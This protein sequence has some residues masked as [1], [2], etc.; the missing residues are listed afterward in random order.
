MQNRKSLATGLGAVLAWVVVALPVTAVSA[1]TWNVPGNGSNVCTVGNPNCNTIQSAVTASTSGDTILI[2]AGT[3]S[4]TGNYSIA[5]TK[6]L[7]ITGAGRAS[8]FVQPNAGAYGFSIRAS[9]ITISDLAIQN[10]G[11]GINFQSASS[12]NT[13]FQ[14]VDFSGNTSRGVDI[15]TAA[16][17]TVTNVLIDDCSFATPNIG[18]RMASN[19]KVNGLTLAS[20]TF[21]GNLYGVYQA[22][23]GNTST[24]INF[25]VD[26]CTFTNNSYWGIYSEEMRDATIQDSTFTNNGVAIL[27]LKI[28]GTSGVAASN[29]TVQRNQFTQVGGGALDFE[30]RAGGGLENPINI[31]DNTFNLDVSAFTSNVSAIFVWLSNSD[32]HAAVNVTDNAFSFTG[33][34]GAASAAY[35]LRI[36][37]NGPLVMTG[38]VLDGGNIGGSGNTPATSGLYIEANSSGGSMPASATLSAT[39]NL[40]TGF[41]NG[42]SVYD[43]PGGVYGGLVSGATVTLNDDDLAGNSDF[44]VINGAASET[45]DAQSNWWGCSAGPGNAGCDDVSG[46][47]DPSNPATAPAPCTPC[48]NAAQCDDDNACTV[49]SCSATC[50]NTPGN[51]GATCRGAAD[52]C[53]LAETCDGVNAACPAD[54]KS[55]A[56]CR[57]SAGVCDVPESCDGVNDACPADEKSTAVCRPGVGVCDVA[58]SCDGVNDDCPADDFAS[59]SVECRPSV[60]TCDTAETCTGSS[61]DCPADAKSTAVC[62]AAAGACDV[63]ETCD[64]VSDDC[65]A[66]VLQSDGTSCS[67]GAFCNGDEECQ[68]GVCQSG[69]APCALLCNEGT[70]QCETGCPAAPQTCRTA[71]RS[72]LLVKDKAADDKDK[73][74]WKWIKGESTSQSEFSDP[75]TTANYAFCVYAGTASALVGEAVVPPGSTDWQE[76]STKGYKYKYST[77]SADGITKVLLKGS[78]QDRSKVLVKG[79]GTDLPDLTLPIS[80]P[81]TVQLVNG[82]TGLCWGADFSAAQLLKNDSSLLKAKAQ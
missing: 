16:A 69:T 51:P 65:P 62:R 29:I 59:A 23:D 81:V 28:W 9:D 43:S 64:G 19:S 1:T 26:N 18:L 50:S 31:A 57:P 82:D 10:G 37:G 46:A 63:A 54:M 14:R 34:F 72:I 25:T 74:V 36:R 32:T 47:V 80:P 76:L 45:V 5:L 13:K 73:L 12:N 27:L 22:N 2:G 39:C 55:S 11:T 61:A 33:S 71:A 60:G 67:D 20:T 41:R 8:T 56:V 30:I 15:S 38:N 79:K 70:D 21:T 24:L 17:L 68:G 48:T 75:R 6:S 7:T 44:G 35:G 78:D 3:F 52:V 77:G 53:D 40:I 58:E 42:V 66:D 49:D 4:G